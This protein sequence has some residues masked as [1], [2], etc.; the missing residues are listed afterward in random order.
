MKSIEQQLKEYGSA[1]SV[2]PDKDHLL[3]TARR[4]KRIYFENAK[5]GTCSYFE[6]LY[7]QSKFIQKRWWVLQ[8]VILFLLYWLV[9]E[10]QEINDLVQ[11][12]MGVLAPVFVIMLVPEL[13]KNRRQGSME[14]EGAAFYSLRQI[15]AARMLFFAVSDG[16]LLSIFSTMVIFTTDLGAKEMLLQFFLPMIITCCICFRTLCSR[17]ASSEYLAVSL[18]MLM[19]AVW[20]FL[21]QDPIYS[22]ISFPAWIAVCCFTA[23]YLIYV[24]RKMIN[25][26]ENYWEASATWN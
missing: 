15:Y 9:H 26:C 1:A 13:N 25:E 11:R 16:L 24:I 4:S 7:Q 17:L 6:F 14:I 3:L 18:S 2:A 12:A 10:E 19:S 5:M 8:F 20:L 21:L 22:A 23:L